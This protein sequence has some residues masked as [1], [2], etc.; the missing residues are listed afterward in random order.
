MGTVNYIKQNWDK[1]GVVALSVLCVVC[2]GVMVLNLYREVKIKHLPA[3]ILETKPFPVIISHAKYKAL[4]ASFKEPYVPQGAHVRNIFAQYQKERPGIKPI[5]EITEF[6]TIQERLRVTKIYKKPVKLLFKGYIQLADG[7]YVATIN[8]AGKTDFRKIGE[9]IRGYK[10]VDFKKEV[11][12]Q[13]TLWG[14]TEKVDKSTIV[15]ERTTGERFSLEIGHITLEKEIFA[16]LWDRKEARSY[17]VHIGSE[18]LDY[19]VLDI[20][21][22]E[23]I[24]ESPIGERVCLSR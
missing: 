4:V 22:V 1:A 9:E 23:V 3:S 18:I 6:K 16:E 20:S 13:K 17:D 12:E 21:P 7:A 10:V 14:G 11:T 24:I 15:L 19:K 2:I 5:P 8:W